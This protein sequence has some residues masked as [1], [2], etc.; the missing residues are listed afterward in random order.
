[1]TQFIKRLLNGYPMKYEGCAF[2]D[3]VSG[4]EVNY[5]IDTLGRKW[6]ANY[7][8]SLFRVRIDG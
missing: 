1:M 7:P 5:Y 2:V 6:M 3:Q 8:W 4:K